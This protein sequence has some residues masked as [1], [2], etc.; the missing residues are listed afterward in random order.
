MT[1]KHAT[2]STARHSAINTNL[3]DCKCGNLLPGSQVC[4][5]ARHRERARRNAS[6][7]TG[8]QHPPHGLTS[9][10]ASKGVDFARRIH[11]SEPLNGNWQRPGGAMIHVAG[12]LSPW[13]L[14]VDLKTSNSGLFW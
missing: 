3:F 7:V 9:F 12:S 10:N 5:V 4:E 2:N 1:A 8:L 13:H 6:V 14:T 11:T